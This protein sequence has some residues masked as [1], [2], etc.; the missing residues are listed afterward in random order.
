MKKEQKLIYSILIIV[1]VLYLFSFFKNS[2]LK[3]NNYTTISSQLKNSIFTEMGKVKDYTKNLIVDL[4]KDELKID[5]NFMSL[6]GSVRVL[7]DNLSKLK[8]IN[9]TQLNRYRLRIN[10]MALTFDNYERFLDKVIYY[11]NNGGEAFSL[12]GS[13]GENIIIKSKQDIHNEFLMYYDVLSNLDLSPNNNEID[14]L[15]YKIILNWDI[16]K[17]EKIYYPYLRSLK[18]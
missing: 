11:I 15:F 8:Y 10:S 17:A 3:I 6:Y 1:C 18:E 12:S 13:G 14:E 4:E 7:N 5:Y 2:N 9:D 16:S